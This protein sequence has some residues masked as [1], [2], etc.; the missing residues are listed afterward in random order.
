LPEIVRALKTF[1]AR[2]INIS[3]STQGRPVWHRN[4][5]EH[6]ILNKKELYA[7]RRYIRDNPLKWD[8]DEDNPVNY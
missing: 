7:A 1:S 4:Y 5:Y 6:V 2:Q 8:K 3:R